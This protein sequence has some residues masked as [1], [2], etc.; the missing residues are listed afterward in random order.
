MPSPSTLSG[1]T[2]LILSFLVASGPLDMAQQWASLSSSQRQSLKQQY[3]DA[4]ISVMVSAFGSTESPTT[5]GDDPT[6]LA[7]TMAQ[8]VLDNDLDGIDIDYEDF[9]AMNA[10]DGSAENWLTTFTQTLRQ[11][12]PQGQY[13]LTHAPVAPWFIGAPRY[14]SGAYAQVDKKV[15]S[16]I[17][18]YNVQFYNQGSSEY[19]TCSGLL[20]QSSSAWPGTALFQIAAAGVD[21]NKLLI[22]KVGKPTDATNG[23]YIDTN[24]L[25]G[26]VQQAQAKGW[27]GGVMVWEFPSADSA[28]ITSV[29]A[30]SWPVGSGSGG[31]GGGN[32]GSGSSS[33]S[34]TPTSTSKHSHTSGAGGTTN[35]GSTPSSCNNVP[36]WDASSIYLVNDSVSYNGMTYTA[37][38]WTQGDVP[39]QSGQWG[40]WKPGQ[41]C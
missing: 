8:F 24:T 29:R 2:V 16:L 7:N 33:S 37:K 6:Q 13:I 41:S 18:W 34:S 10:M 15:G 36:A 11:K 40:V 31:N 25:A 22:G 19:T 12:L 39:D 14:K 23:G 26:C 3:N 20:D 30:Q 28:W 35:V 9:A 17:D 4:G 38:W 32:G 5:A 27:Q 21:Q 1:Y